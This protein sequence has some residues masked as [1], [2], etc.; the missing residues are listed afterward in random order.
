[1]LDPA[2]LRDNLEAVRSRL[3]K[4]GTDFSRELEELATLET[5]PTPPVAGDRGHEA[6]AERRR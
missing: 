1:M 4:R 5:Q 2:F 3:Q 6:R